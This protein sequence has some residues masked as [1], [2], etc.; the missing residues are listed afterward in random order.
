MDRFYR[1][2]NIQGR[3]GFFPLVV[4]AGMTCLLFL[5]LFLTWSVLRCATGVDTL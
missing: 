2:G 4:V 1:E 5:L 3:R